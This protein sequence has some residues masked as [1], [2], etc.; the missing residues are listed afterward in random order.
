MISVVVLPVSIIIQFS[1]ISAAILDVAI[2]FAA[3]T[4]SGLSTSSSK[5]K[6]PFIPIKPTGTEKDSLDFLAMSITPSLFVL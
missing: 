6:T 4:S 5:L 2:Q 1:S 3:A